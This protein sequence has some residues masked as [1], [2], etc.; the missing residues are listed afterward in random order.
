MKKGKDKYEIKY[1]EVELEFAFMTGK[2]EGKKFKTFYDFMEY[3]YPKQKNY[4]S[5]HL[6][7]NKAVQGRR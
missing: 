3:R 6:S 7:I 1:R 5:K 2:L 4:D